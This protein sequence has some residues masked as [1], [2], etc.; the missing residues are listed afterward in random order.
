MA[1]GVNWEIIGGVGLKKK[2]QFTKKVEIGRFSLRGGGGGVYTL[3]RYK[4]DSKTNRVTW[5]ARVRK[6]SAAHIQGGGKFR[7]G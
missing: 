6:V 5:E 2:H 7:G 3:P 1:S 4:S